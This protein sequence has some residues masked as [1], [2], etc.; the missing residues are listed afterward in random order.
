[1]N[2]FAGHAVLHLSISNK[3]TKKRT[4]LLLL[5]G[6]MNLAVY[7]QAM[8]RSSESQLQLILSPAQQSIGQNIQ[9][10]IGI[11]SK[12]GGINIVLVKI[13][14]GT[15]RMGS[16]R[17]RENEIPV[18][19][20]TISR[21][22]WMGK[23]V[24]TQAQYEGVMGRNPGNWKKPENPVNQVTWNDVQAFL[25]ELSATQKEFDFRLPTEAEWEYACR[26]GT[27]G[28]TYG[29]LKTIAWYGNALFGSVHPVGQ[30]EP[31]A[32]GLYDMLGNVFQWCQDI[33]GPYTAEDQVDPLGPSSGQFRLFRG[34]SYPSSK[35]ECSAS[36]RQ[37]ISPNYSYRALGFRIVAIERKP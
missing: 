1:M 23:Y 24:I 27:T 3:R 22:F 33:Y 31:N 30:K 8:G 10:I 9:K 28:E 12:C 25:K 35:S 15:F 36:F 16:A 19:N 32:F 2:S 37:F 14:S 13:P 6:L 29:P 4:I 11:P 17:G 21:D 26:A 20:V 5:L 18:H 34:C 7:A